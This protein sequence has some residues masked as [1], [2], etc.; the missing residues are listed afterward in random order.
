MTV[1]KTT[2]CGWARWDYDWDAGSRVPGSG[3]VEL[4]SWSIV[5][6]MNFWAVAGHF[7]GMGMTTPPSNVQCEANQK[8][9]N[10]PWAIAPEQNKRESDRCLRN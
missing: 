7:H 1:C 4:V 3:I 8:K 10:G 2:H 6:A 9:A 5:K